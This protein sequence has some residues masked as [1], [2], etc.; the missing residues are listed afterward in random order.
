[1]SSINCNFSHNYTS[2][3]KCTWLYGCIRNFTPSHPIR[4]SLSGQYYNDAFAKLYFFNV[5]KIKLYSIFA[6]EK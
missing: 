5:D 6:V 4:Y 1:M 3:I 2:S